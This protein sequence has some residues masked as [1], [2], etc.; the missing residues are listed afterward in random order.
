MKFV[1]LRSKQSE[2]IQDVMRKELPSSLE[3]GQVTSS[4]IVKSVELLKGNGT[5]GYLAAPFKLEDS[6]ILCYIHT[7]NW[8]RVL[9]FVEEIEYNNLEIVSELENVDKDEE[10]EDGVDSEKVE[11]NSSCF[12]LSQIV[13]LKLSYK[14]KQNTKERYV[15]LPFDSLGT[16]YYESFDFDVNNVENDALAKVQVIHVDEDGNEINSDDEDDESA[17]AAVEKQPSSSTSKPTSTPSPKSTP[18]EQCHPVDDLQRLNGK[19]YLSQMKASHNGQWIQIKNKTDL[20]WD[21]DA[22]ENWLEVSVGE[23]QSYGQISVLDKEKKTIRFR[24]PGQGISCN[25]VFDTLAPVTTFRFVNPK[26]DNSKGLYSAISEFQ[27]NKV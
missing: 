5:H 4:L 25:I 9:Y 26:Y 23:D 10:D 12:D 18:L 27:M 24:L 15:I 8:N 1:D 2:E 20:V 13:H 14:S 19:F 16:C 11:N 3:I 6:S 7:M 21:F 22:K 17:P